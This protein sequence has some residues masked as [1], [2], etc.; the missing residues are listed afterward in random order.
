M[1][2]RLPGLMSH[3]S[4]FREQVYPATAGARSS[5]RRRMGCGFSL[6]FQGLDHTWGQIHTCGCHH[7]GHPECRG[8]VAHSG[9]RAL[10]SEVQDR[11]VVLPL[12]HLQA[13]LLC[14]GPCFYLPRV[15]WHV[16]QLPDTRPGSAC[17]VHFSVYTFPASCLYLMKY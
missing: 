7:T 8:L 17:V 6:L 9:D 16:S 14:V 4:C 5:T 13:V 10:V 12:C 1:D 2:I 3:A 15:S 11:G